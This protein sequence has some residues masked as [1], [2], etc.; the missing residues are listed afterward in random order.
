MSIAFY[1]LAI[2]ALYLGLIV[3]N[4]FISVLFFW[5]AFDFFIIA[6]AYWMNKPLIFGKQQDGKLN[7]V[8]LVLLFPYYFFIW[9]VWRLNLFLDKSE[10]YH[11]LSQNIWI[12]RRLLDKEAIQNID[13]IIDL[14]C[15][16]SESKIII[17][18]KGYLCFPILDGGVPNAAEFKTLLNH[19][20]NYKGNIYIHCALGSG[21]TGLVACSYLI[22][23]SV[24]KTF[25]EAYILVQLKRNNIR[26]NHLQ[27]KFLKNFHN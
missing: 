1:I 24:A 19:I 14:T 7:P 11:K 5:Y 6:I 16:F 15:E 13:L 4:R 2:L 12:G 20:Y 3:E 9:S 27:I 8:S 10:A 17:R 22:F 25:N 26:L 18:D 23:I 21:R